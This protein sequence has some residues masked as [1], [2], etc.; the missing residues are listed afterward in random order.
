MNKIFMVVWRFLSWQAFC[1]VCIQY[2][3][4]FCPTLCPVLRKCVHITTCISSLLYI[5]VNKSGPDVLFLSGFES[6]I[7]YKHNAPQLS[8]TVCLYQ[9]PTIISYCLSI[10]TPHNYLFTVR[11]YQHPTII[12]YHLSIS[13]PH[14][15]LL[16]LSISIPPQLSLTVSLYQHPTIIS[17]CLSNSNS[18]SLWYQQPP[19]MKYNRGHFDNVGNITLHYTFQLGSQS[20]YKHKTKQNLFIYRHVCM[21]MC[22]FEH[23]HTSPSAHIHAYTY[24]YIHKYIY[25]WLLARGRPHSDIPFRYPIIAKA[26]NKVAETP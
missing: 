1:V 23:V 15:Y 25:T 16:P 3:C 17:Y 26:D 8:L 21:Y 19:C 22:A 9:H 4:M 2:H 18:K 12:S 6:S 13:T 10:S 24:I 14:N 11:L 5:G 20:Y 7:I